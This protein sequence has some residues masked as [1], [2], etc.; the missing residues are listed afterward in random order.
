LEIKR[1]GGITSLG[2]VVVAVHIV[3]RLIIVVIP[4][5]NGGNI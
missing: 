2:P 4:G 5:E 3:V 1:L